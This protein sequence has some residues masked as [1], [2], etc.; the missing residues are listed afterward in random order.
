MGEVTKIEWCDRNATGRQLGAYKSAAAKT[1]C[2]LEEWF[3]RTERGLLWCSVCRQWEASE[4]FHIDLSRRR[5]RQHCCISCATRLHRC[6]SYNLSRVELATL[7]TEKCPI[8]E[9]FGQKMELDHDH[10]SGVVRGFL[11]S[12]CNGALGQFCDDPGLLTRAIAYLEKHHG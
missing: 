7:E 8:C 11:C 4:E 5:G 3:D 12:R 9:R 2:S 10:K 6:T 1:G